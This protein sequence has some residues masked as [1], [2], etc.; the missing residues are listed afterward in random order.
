M[1]LLS[2]GELGEQ[3]DL[4]SVRRSFN[5]MKLQKKGATTRTGNFC[6]GRQQYFVIDDKKWPNSQ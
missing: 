5:L 6:R 4:S 3:A 1:K 2:N